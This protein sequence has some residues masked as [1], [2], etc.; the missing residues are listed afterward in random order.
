M[1]RKYAYQSALRR[2]L[3]SCFDTAGA[4]LFSPLRYAPRPA[5]VKKILAV[6]VDHLGDVLMTRPALQ[7]L[8]SIYPA[9][10]IHL[11]TSAEAVR[12]LGH[13]PCADRL[14]AFEYNWFSRGAKPDAIFKSA[15]AMRSCLQETGYDLAVDFRG[16]LRTIL[17]L[18]LARI[19]FRAGYGITG[20]G[21]LLHRCPEYPWTL[22]QADANIRLLEALS[23]GAAGQAVTP[24]KIPVSKERTDFFKNLLSQTSQ[25]RPTVIIHA[26]AGYGLKKWPDK[27]FSDLIS[28]FQKEAH[29]TL[30]GTSEE[31]KDSLIPQSSGILDLRGKTVL[32]DLPALF[33]SAGL[34]IGNDSGPAHLAAA[35][36]VAVIS[37][38]NKMNNPEIWKPRGNHVTVLAFD[39]SQPVS[40]DEVLQ[41]ARLQ[42]KEGR[43]A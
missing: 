16:D 29:I 4:L 18:A 6:R 12:L 21:F 36:G 35:Q 41:T 2:F 26:G 27:N 43:P 13:D 20:G 25:G 9:A 22:H 30:I 15:R 37:L 31:K 39:A 5:S 17:L 32:E 10:E 40:A 23:P 42:L 34:F 3:V 28:R 38:F 7:T 11:L 24:P 33:E 1:A 14:I 8:R 19:P